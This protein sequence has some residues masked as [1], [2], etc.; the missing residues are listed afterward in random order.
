MA[1]SLDPRR[2][3]RVASQSPAGV[4]PTKQARME[5]APVANMMPAQAPAQDFATI[6]QSMI[7]EAIDA[8][9]AKF[10]LKHAEKAHDVATKKFNSTKHYHEQFPTIEEQHTRELKLA[11]TRYDAALTEFDKKHRT[12]KQLASQLSGALPEMSSG[13]DPTTESRFKDLEKEV[14]DLRTKEANEIDRVAPLQAEIKK[15]QETADEITAIRTDLKAL[16]DTVQNLQTQPP[17]TQANSTNNDSAFA[18][19]VPVPPPTDEDDAPLEWKQKVDNDIQGLQVW[20]GAVDRQYHNLTTEEVV[21]NMVD[22]MSKIYPHAKN[23]QVAIDNIN[24]HIA[25]LEANVDSIPSMRQEIESLQGQLIQ[26]IKEY[27]H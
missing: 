6:L 24:N 15:L 20:I 12:V 8:G 1:S 21:R 9:A 2:Q 3:K 7:S 16:Q 19:F 4:A 5:Q 26:A 27:A 23:V 14:G 13:P 11:S 17:A 10:T 18:P 22:Q 25:Q